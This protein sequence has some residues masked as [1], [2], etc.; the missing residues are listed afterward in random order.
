MNRST[1]RLSWQVELTSQARGE[2]FRVL[3][4]A[5]TGEAL[6]RHGLTYY[7]SEATYRVFASDSPSPFS[8]GHAAPSTDQPRLVERQLVTLSALC[9]QRF[10]EWL[11]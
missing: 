5:Q 8:P 3:V 1:M 4:D 6:I 2:L 9:Y 10:A 7:I 11:D